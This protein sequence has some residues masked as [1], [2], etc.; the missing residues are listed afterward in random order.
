MALEPDDHHVAIVGLETE[1]PG[2]LHKSAEAQT[3]NQ[4]KHGAPWLDVGV[5]G[6]CVPTTISILPP[7]LNKC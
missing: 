7:S 4:R 1:G 2:H 6:C 5:V 3:E